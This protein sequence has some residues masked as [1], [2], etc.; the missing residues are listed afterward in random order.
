MPKTKKKFDWEIYEGIEFIDMLSMSRDEMR[1]YQ[2]AHPEYTI[3]EVGY[4]DDGNDNSWEA[5]SEKRGN[6]YSVRI[7]KR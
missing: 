2:K 5:S 6:V 1:E 7:R 4:T 3:K